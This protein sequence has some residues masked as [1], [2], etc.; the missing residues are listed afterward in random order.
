MEKESALNQTNTSPSVP[1]PVLP[2]FRPPNSLLWFSRRLGQAATRPVSGVRNL[3]KHDFA[4]P[5]AEQLFGTSNPLSV[6]SWRKD[7]DK[8]Q[9]S[10]EKLRSLAARSHEIIAQATTVFPFT[11][12][13][14]TVTL[15]RTKVTIRRRD[16]FWSENV[17]SIRIEDVLNATVATDL[18]FGSLNV[19]SRVMNSTDHYQLRFFRKAEAMHLKHLIQGYVI[20]QHNKIDVEHLDKEA[21]IETLQELGHDGKH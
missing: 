18:L 14:D 16:F 21:L 9:S 3:I 19:A 17:V 12:F 13:P 6:R 2:K 15:D 8:N 10:R 4:L 1:R 20:A 11:L 7:N 5:S